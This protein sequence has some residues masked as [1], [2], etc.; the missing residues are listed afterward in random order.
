MA[1]V[2]PTQGVE[3]IA[4]V[5]GLHAFGRFQIEDRIRPGAQR[6]A[7]IRRGQKAGGEHH[8]S[9][10]DA[11]FQQ[12]DKGGQVV[13]LAAESVDDPRA[14]AGP[15]Q[16]RKAIVEQVER[17][18][19]R[20]AVVIHGTDDGDIVDAL[21]E[22]GKE[23]RD[24]NARLAVLAEGAPAADD[25]LLIE[26]GELQLH[27]SEAGGHELAVEFVERGLG[28]EGFQMR[29]SAV[30]EEKDDAAGGGREMRLA[31]GHGM[32][33]RRRGE[34]REA[35]GRAEELAAVNRHRG[36]R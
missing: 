11:A 30:H 16:A 20:E 4:L 26:F 36:T 34:G 23:I 22:F 18:S 32:E 29:R 12:H 24:F 7:L 5:G 10:L 17:G 3:Q 6:S 8:G 27:A 28:V 31:R 25:G 2:E 9:A 14:H 21:R 15:A 35:E 33:C 1:F 19:V 13:A